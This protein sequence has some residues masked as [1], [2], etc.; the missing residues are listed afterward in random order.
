MY[1]TV[2]VCLI[3]PLAPAP[4]HLPLSAIFQALLILHDDD[5]IH[6]N[7]K[8]LEPVCH[9]LDRLYIEILTFILGYYIQW[10]W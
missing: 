9:S 10:N 3:I 8:A 6:L 7:D 4:A 1:Y 5:Q 2:N